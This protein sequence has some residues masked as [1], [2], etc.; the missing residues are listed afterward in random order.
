MVKFPPLEHLSQTNVNVPK[1]VF[2][3]PI[4]Y[5][6]AYKPFVAFPRSFFHIPHLLVSQRYSVYFPS[7]FSN[8]FRDGQSDSLSE[9]KLSARKTRST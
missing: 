4:Y 3:C 6:K 1:A 2:N 7:S 8:W 9:L 5:Q